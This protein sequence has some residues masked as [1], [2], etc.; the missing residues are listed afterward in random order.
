MTAKTGYP[1]LPG[2]AEAIAGKGYRAGI[3]TAPFSAAETSELFARH[4]DWM[5]AEGGKPKP[6]YRGWGKTIYA[7]DTTRPEVKAWL[8]ETIAALRK[9]G[10]SYLKIDF[11]FAAAMPGVRHKRV[12][13]IQAYR[14]G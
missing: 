11:L 9:A 12:T 5:V 8:R 2:L 1:D 13:P 3:W 10:F 7:L 14:E 6:C 4:P